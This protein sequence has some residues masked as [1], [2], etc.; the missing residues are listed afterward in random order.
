MKYFSGKHVADSVA[1]VHA[2]W[3][4]AAAGSI[5]AVIIWPNIQVYV[6]WPFVAMVSSWV[7]WKDCPLT[8]MERWLRSK[9]D[10][11]RHFDGEGF[12]AHY[13]DK[14]TGIRISHHIA[15]RISYVYTGAVFLVIWMV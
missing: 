5:P 12:L 4:I 1:V 14:V 10:P 2:A 13:F 8:R 9:W 7:V 6:F 3:G 15:Q 11:K